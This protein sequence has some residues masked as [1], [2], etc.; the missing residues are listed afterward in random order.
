[1]TNQVKAG[2]ILVPPVFGTT[3]NHLPEPQI[4]HNGTIVS[5][6][7]SID[8]SDCN[9]TYLR[10]L[11][12][13]I[14]TSTTT[15]IPYLGKA[16]AAVLRDGASRLWFNTFKYAAGSWKFHESDLMERAGE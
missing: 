16:V 7:T 4:K 14:Y 11:D 13:T 8:P 12:V 9:W 2:V 5:V 10:D 6:L 1:M 3:H 15:C